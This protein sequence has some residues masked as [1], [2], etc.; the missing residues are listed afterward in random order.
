MK[1]RITPFTRHTYLFAIHLSRYHVRTHAG[2]DT[3]VRAKGQSPTESKHKFKI[4][5]YSYFLR[6]YKFYYILYKTGGKSRLE[7]NLD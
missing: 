2:L 1:L 3:P 6:V 7:D 5:S 4:T